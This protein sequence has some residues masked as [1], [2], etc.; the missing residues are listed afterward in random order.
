M[1]YAKDFGEAR[2]KT[3]LSRVAATVLALAAILLLTAPGRATASPSS[4]PS[5]DSITEQV[6]SFLASHPGS[7]LIGENTVQA[8]PGVV[9]KFSSVKSRSAQEAYVSCSTQTICW[10]DNAN[11]GGTE[12]DHYLGNDH[13]GDCFWWSK[14]LFRVS[15]YVNNTTFNANVTDVH[16]FKIYTAESWTSSSYVGSKNNDQN[17]TY[18][19]S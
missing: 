4:T 11:W 19:L 5:G 7:K 17:G 14:L 8:R 12:E 9:V 15:S 13:P 10:F 6:A 1:I 3:K 2:V 16:G 18:C